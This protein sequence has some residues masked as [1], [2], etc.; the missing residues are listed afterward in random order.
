[1]QPFLD[2]I[3]ADLAALKSGGNYR[4][5]REIA[6]EGD[7]R[8]RYDG[9]VLCNLSSNDYLG[10]AGDAELREDFYRQYNGDWRTPEL[11][12]SSASSE[13]TSILVT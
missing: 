5:L 12:L 11:A 9:R 3:R 10:L 6:P 2:D 7:G 1:M 13:H 4:A 8:S